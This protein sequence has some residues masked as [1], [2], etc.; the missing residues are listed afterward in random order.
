MSCFDFLKH[1]YYWLTLTFFLCFL[2]GKSV[3]FNLANALFRDPF[4]SHPHGEVKGSISWPLEAVLSLKGCRVLPARIE[5]SWT[6]DTFLLL[7]FCPTFN[8]P[9]IK[10]W[11]E[12]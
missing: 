10:Y 4:P 2:G 3:V 8:N 11:A 12:I 7:L 6:T 5:C 1:Y 9:L